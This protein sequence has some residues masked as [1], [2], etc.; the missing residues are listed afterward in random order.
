MIRVQSCRSFVPAVELGGEEEPR[1]EA[2]AHCGA[3]WVVMCARVKLG[4]FHLGW[5]VHGT[6]P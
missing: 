2:E 4:L 3:H 1:G 6:H 5:D